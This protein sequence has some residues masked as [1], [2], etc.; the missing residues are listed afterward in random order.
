[1]ARPKLTA[2]GHLDSF[3]TARVFIFASSPD[4]SYFTARATAREASGRLVAALGAK[5]PSCPESVRVDFEAADPGVIL[6]I[7]GHVLWS[8]EDWIHV[9]AGLWL[10]DP[11]SAAMLGVGGAS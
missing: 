4:E 9:A 7:H 1:M 3:D 5:G 10:W 6:V 2:T 8:D 11:E